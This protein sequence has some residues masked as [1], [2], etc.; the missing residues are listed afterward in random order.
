MSVYGIIWIKRKGYIRK[1]E[2]MDE[3]RIQIKQDIKTLKNEVYEQGVRIKVV[4]DRLTEFMHDV[5]LLNHHLRLMDMGNK[6][7]KDNKAQKKKDI[8]ANMKGKTLLK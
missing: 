6:W 2:V 1:G 4:E 5:E 3:E 7:F 8:Q